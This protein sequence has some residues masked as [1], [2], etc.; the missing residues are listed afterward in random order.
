M[1][2]K[3]TLILCA[4]LVIYMKFDV[5][6]LYMLEVMLPTKIKYVTSGN[7]SKNNDRIKD[8]ALHLSPFVYLCMKLEVKSIYTFE[9]LLGTKKTNM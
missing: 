5:N 4:A 6:G 9:F 1:K 2:D 7:K 8:L 3:Y